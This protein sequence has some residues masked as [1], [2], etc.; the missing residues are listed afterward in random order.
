M[1]R[2]IFYRLHNINLKEN[3]EKAYTVEPRDNGT[4]FKGEPLIKVNIFGPN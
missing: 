2:Y 3:N 4:A 1:L